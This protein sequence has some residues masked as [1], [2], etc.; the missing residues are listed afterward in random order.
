ME[1]SVWRAYI[2]DVLVQEALRAF[3]VVADKELVALRL[4]PRAKPELRLGCCELGEAFARPETHTSFSTVPS[5]RGSSCAALP[6]LYRMAMIFRPLEA[7]LLKEAA[8]RTLQVALA[9]LDPN[10]C[11][12]GATRTMHVPSLDGTGAS[13]SEH[14]HFGRDWERCEGGGRA[15]WVWAVETPAMSRRLLYIRA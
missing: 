11:S 10:A 15:D 12:R 13:T 5:R 14:R 3:L 8:L 6:P 2:L 1:I 4:E 9:Q 7:C